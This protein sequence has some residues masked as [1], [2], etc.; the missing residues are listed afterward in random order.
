[1]G[2]NQ[3]AIIG[4]YL[5]LFR[6]KELLL[7]QKRGG[8]DRDGIYLPLAG[9]VEEGETVIEAIIREAKEEANILLEPKNLQVSVVVHRQNSDYFLEKRDIIDFFIYASKYSG[10]IKNNEPEKCYKIDFY[11]LDNL[12]SPLIPHMNLVINAYFTKKFYL[13]YP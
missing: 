1:M 4:A 10:E 5:L 6:D 13:I 2:I 8:G 9:H 3:T 12:P 7:T 11:P